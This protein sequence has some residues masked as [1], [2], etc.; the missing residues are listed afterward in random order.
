M[1]ALMKS[2]R[3]IPIFSLFGLLLSAAPALAA[4]TGAEVPEPSDL[5]L[6]ALGL[7]GVILGYRAVRVQKKRDADPA[8]KRKPT[9]HR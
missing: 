8:P 9:E 6:F 7:L 4:P 3:I 5:A 2:M 1:I